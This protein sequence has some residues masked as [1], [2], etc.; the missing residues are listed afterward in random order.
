MTLLTT[1]A[2]CSPEVLNDNFKEHHNISA[3]RTSNP[4]DPRDSD[5]AIFGQTFGLTK[6]RLPQVDV[7]VL[8]KNS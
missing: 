6:P 4:Q 1:I 8:A 5:F 7:H 2:W 3:T